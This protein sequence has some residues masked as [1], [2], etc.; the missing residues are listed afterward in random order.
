MK[1]KIEPFKIEYNISAIISYLSV[2]NFPYENDV[3]EIF[4]FDIL[5]NRNTEIEI[6]KKNFAKK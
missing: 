5:K 3:A 2:L 4:K 6:E 1:I